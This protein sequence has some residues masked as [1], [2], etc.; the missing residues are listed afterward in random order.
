MGE[1]TIDRRLIFLAAPAVLFVALNLL[2]AGDLVPIVHRVHRRAALLYADEP[3][4]AVLFASALAGLAAVFGA[5]VEVKKGEGRVFLHLK[6]GALP[7]LVGGI[8]M[9]FA[10]GAFY[11]GEYL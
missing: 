11:L 5:S 2:N 4:A 8:T 10:F 6:N 7:V 9:L 1:L 3:G